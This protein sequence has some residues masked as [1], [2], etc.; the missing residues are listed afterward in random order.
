MGKWRKALLAALLI[1]AADRAVAMGSRYSVTITPSLFRPQGAEMFT[2]A[3]D[4]FTAPVRVFFDLGNGAPPRE[5]F[6]VSVTSRQIVGVTPPIDLGTGQV[7]IASV[8]YLNASGTPYETRI[9]VTNG[10]IYRIALLTPE[11]TTLSPNQG[12][13]TGG[14]RVTIFGLGFDSP[15]QVFFDDVE[16]QVIYVNI[17]QVT[18]MSPP[19]HAIGAASVRVVNINADKSTTVPNAYRYRPP[20]ALSAMSP[21]SGPAIGG[22]RIT[23]D[24]V[25]FSDP[26]SS[27]SPASRRQ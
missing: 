13:L 6:V 12:P 14:S 5:A 21:T 18:V 27:P 8:Y 15:I 23:I 19:G 7:K 17:N 9:N 26:M 4:Y 25:G 3:G 22:T 11:I 24:G 16:A 2:I 20:F 10:V 1:V